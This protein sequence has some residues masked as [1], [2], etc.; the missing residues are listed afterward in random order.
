M[1]K[2]R[3]QHW[4]RLQR[5]YRRAVS[6]E[7]PNPERKDCP[8]ADALRHL[9]SMPP[10]DLQRNPEWKH[11]LQCGPCYEEYFAFRNIPVMELEEAE[12]GARKPAKS[13]APSRA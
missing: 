1:S 5:E 8:G 6:I 13:G 2:K 9:V 4:D 12:S 10:E 3:Q 11:A 7:Y